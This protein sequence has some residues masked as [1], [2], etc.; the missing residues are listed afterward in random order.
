V[1]R[2]TAMRL[3][4]RVAEVNRLYAAVLAA[5]QDEVERRR[6]AELVRA[7]ALLSAVARG[8]LGEVSIRPSEAL[9]L[10]GIPRGSRVG[11]RASNAGRVADRIAAC[12]QRRS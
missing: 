11:R 10:R 4:A 9:V 3:R 1:G 7:S 6:L 8:A 12:A 5:Q 2:E